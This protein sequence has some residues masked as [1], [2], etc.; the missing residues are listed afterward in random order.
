M[1][2]YH[3]QSPSNIALVKYWG[4]HG[5]Q[6]PANPSISFTLEKCLS[7]TKLTL[8]PR[9]EDRIRFSFEGKERADF[10]PKI[11]SFLK[12]V[13]HFVPFISDYSVEIE[14]SNT[15]PHS[16]GIASSASSMSALALCLASASIDHLGGQ[17]DLQLA[18]EMARLG[19][20]SACRSVYGGY[21]L[22]GE[23]EHKK[24]SSDRFAIQLDDIHPEF[25]DLQDTILL[26][27]EGEKQVSST[28]GHDL[29]KGHPFASARFE[30]AQANIKELL[31][32]QAKGD[33]MELAD[34]IEYEALTLHAMMMTSSPHFILFKPG[35]VSVIRRVMELRKS[36]HP[37]SFT[38][39]AG[40]N[41][42][43]IYPESFAQ[44][45]MDIVRGEFVGYCQN[46]VYIC[47]KIGRGPVEL[48]S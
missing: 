6:L 43:L 41:V 33:F 45:A 47:D 21:T 28:V 31:S 44:E 25:K 40:A 12:R 19:S 14:S 48:D 22:W 32:V 39:D 34:I 38:L 7:D 10:I 29:M 36:G 1:K 23:T 24:G 2:S 26:I 35:S 11:D 27:D 16:S 30:Q 42:H 13:E 9:S 5:V 3:W 4:K 17:L 37:I 46:G 8:I 15:F 20:G 18:S